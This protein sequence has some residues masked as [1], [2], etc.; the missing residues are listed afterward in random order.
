MKADRYHFLQLLWNK[1][2][3]D[4]SLFNDHKLLPSQQHT[5]LQCDFAT[6]LLCW[7]PSS[8][9][10]PW[11]WDWLVASMTWFKFLSLSRKWPCSFD[12]HP[13]QHCSETTILGRKAVWRDQPTLKTT[14]PTLGIM[15]HNQS[16]YFMPLNLE[17][18]CCTAIGNSVYFLIVFLRVFSAQN[19]CED[20]LRVR[21]L[22]REYHLCGSSSGVK[23]MKI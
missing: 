22:Y 16:C 18:V 20:S 21:T 19:L 9:L 8:S 6:A 4:Y 15:R 5:I 12:L 13:I 2:S 11:I 7:G 14:Q 23:P 3:W 10:Q 17:V 1:H